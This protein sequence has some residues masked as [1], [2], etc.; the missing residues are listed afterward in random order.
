MAGLRVVH[1]KASRASRSAA[2][3]WMRHAEGLPFVGRSI[4]QER[5]DVLQGL[6]S[7]L[8]INSQ[9]RTALIALGCPERS[10]RQPRSLKRH[11]D[12]PS[13]VRVSK[14]TG[15]GRSRKEQ[16]RLLMAS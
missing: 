15:I 3:I 4:V 9:G 16:P 6:G 14:R 10:I 11:Q 5:D 8:V 2:L 1:N 13:T 7:S 12:R